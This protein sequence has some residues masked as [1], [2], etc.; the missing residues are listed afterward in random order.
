VGLDVIGGIT[1][2]NPG[3]KGRWRGS[4]MSGSYHNCI[5][6]RRSKWNNAVLIALSQKGYA[7]NDSAIFVQ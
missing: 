5:T 3:K 2:A 4:M 1:P 7:A 6:H